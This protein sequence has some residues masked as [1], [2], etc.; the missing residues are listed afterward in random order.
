MRVHRSFVS[1]FLRLLSSTETIYIRTHKHHR[2]SLYDGMYP[3]PR[4]D[5]R[6]VFVWCVQRQTLHTYPPLPLPMVRPPLPLYRVRRHPIRL[7]HIYC[8][9]RGTVGIQPTLMDDNNAY[10]IREIWIRV[11]VMCTISSLLS[12]DPPP[13]HWSRLNQ[14]KYS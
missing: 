1:L 3:S 2:I 14:I 10:V 4:N 5:V 13:N 7:Y 11:C 8:N 6:N 9:R 12:F